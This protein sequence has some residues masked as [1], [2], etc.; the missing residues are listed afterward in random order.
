[1]TSHQA[2][3]EGRLAEAV[4]LQETAVAENPTH[5][6]RRL[7]LVQLLMFAGR[8]ADARTPLALIDSDAPDWPEL[9]RSFLRL[10]R[11]EHRRSIGRAP[12]VRPEPTPLHAKRRW[13]AIKAI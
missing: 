6:A 13:R 4:S 8:L 12:V 3:A 5:P 2:F 7:L 9:A 10:M 11:A 1:M